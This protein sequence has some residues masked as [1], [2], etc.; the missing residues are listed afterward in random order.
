VLEL[1]VE[2]VLF[3]RAGHDVPLGFL[4]GWLF[5]GRCRVP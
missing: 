4:A 1:F 5:T 3:G 2:P